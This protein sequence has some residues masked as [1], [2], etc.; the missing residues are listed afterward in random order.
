MAWIGGVWKP[1]WRELW[2]HTT[3]CTHSQYFI[4]RKK[5]ILKSSCKNSLKIWSS[6][7]KCCFEIRTA[8]KPHYQPSQRID[9]CCFLHLSVWVWHLAYKSD[10]LVINKLKNLQRLT[11]SKPSKAKRCPFHDEH[12]SSYVGTFLRNL[13]WRRLNL[14]HFSYISLFQLSWFFHRISFCVL[15]LD[16]RRL[17][18]P[19]FFWCISLHSHARPSSEIINANSEVTRSNLRKYCQVDFRIF[20]KHNINCST[21]Q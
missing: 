3:S 12:C 4:C 9:E 13:G 11:I 10:K 19:H 16:L 5:P 1:T 20:E 7:R 18:P 2:K 14:A 8:R 15:G 6:L 21:I 17:N